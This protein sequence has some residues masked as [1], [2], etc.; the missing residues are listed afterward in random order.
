[1]ADTPTTTQLPATLRVRALPSPL[2]L[3]KYS[4]PST[5]AVTV[6]EENSFPCRRCLKDGAVGDE[7][8][9][10][11]YDPFLG[12]SPYRQ[13][14]P[15][16]VHLNPTCGAY[17]PDGALPEQLRRRLLSVRSFGKDHCMV[18]ADVVQGD[19]LD[20]KLSSAHL[21]LTILL[22]QLATFIPLGSS[23]FELARHGQA[24]RDVNPI[25]PPPMNM[26]PSS[27]LSGLIIAEQSSARRARDTP[28]SSSAHL[29]AEA[30]VWSVT[31]PAIQVSTRLLAPSSDL[32]SPRLTPGSWA[33]PGDAIRDAPKCDRRGA[34]ADGIASAHGHVISD[35]P[36][37]HR[38]LIMRFIA[39]VAVLFAGLAA[40]QPV[41]DGDSLVARACKHEACANACCVS[42]GGCN[43]LNCG[44]SYC[45][46]GKC[47]CDC[48]YG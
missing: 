4:S 22:V 16:F 3:S 45:S 37:M 7:M 41:E 31:C 46:G 13:P 35:T 10:T 18:D 5:K 2:E 34:E 11:P 8:L 39:V 12:D 14:G 1:M 19:Q 38:P 47:H 17:K 43:S 33:G 44:T 48:H 6:D 15:I 21:R 20:E 24:V 29:T 36:P 26:P 27:P 30:A 23:C 32:L 9:L 28:P 42:H 40:A 25:S